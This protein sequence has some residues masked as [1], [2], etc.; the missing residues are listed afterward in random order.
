MKQI[1]KI[2]LLIGAIACSIFTQAQT[3]SFDAKE[4]NTAGDGANSVFI[5]HQAGANTLSSSGSNVF[6]G[7]NA[8]IYT[9]IDSDYNV[10]IGYDAGQRI[11]GNSNVFLGHKAGG[12]GH[13]N[14]QT[15]VLHNT[16]VGNSAGLK[17]SSNAEN[18]SI[19]G[20]RA[21]YN[22]TDGSSN[23]LFGYQAGYNLVS[24][25]NNTIVG[26][27]A[28]YNA[29]TG[30]KNIF[31]GY[32]SGY[33]ET[34]SN[35]L[36]I[37]NSNSATPLIYGDFTTDE[38]TF[39]ANVGIGTIDPLGILHAHG[40]GEDAWVY[41]TNNIAGSSNNPKSTKGLAFGYNRSGG[42]GESI[43]NYNKGSGGNP[44]LDFTSYDGTTYAREMTLKDG[45]LGIGTTS[46]S[47]ELDVNGDIH[48][49]NG[50]LQLN[51]TYENAG[52]VLNFITKDGNRH[53][54]FRFKSEKTDNNTTK[55]IMF[56]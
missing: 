47:A 42:S 34:G 12:Y 10:F 6:V 46:P 29:A 11:E 30:N 15:G 38:L 45:K 39:N 33:N 35:K 13:T 19:F 49:H 8:G 27:A 43:I 26:K 25:D 5:G 14:T 21:G 32:Q 31:L 3:T 2:N 9:S 16:I 48:F 17:I 24:G 41:F 22:I 36:Y 18:N 28:G 7:K 44:R 56:L 23:S 4:S 37:E 1:L 40:N 20:R 51:R 52:N 55:T 54:D 50:L 53:G